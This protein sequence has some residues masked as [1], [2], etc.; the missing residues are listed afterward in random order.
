ML[1][2]HKPTDVC[3][4]AVTSC[5]RSKEGLSLTR[6]VCTT[7]GTPHAHRRVGGSDDPW[8][9]A[10]AAAFRREYGVCFRSALRVVRERWLAEEVV[11][12]AFLAAWQHGPTR[13]DPR[14][15]PLELWLI[16][17][18][19]HKAIDAVR[20]AEH[21]KRVRRHEEGDLHSAT[22]KELT[23]DLLLRSQAADGLRDRIRSL[24]VAQQRVLLL[25]YWAGLSQSQIAQCDAIPLGTVKTR[26]SAGL[27]HLRILL[28]DP[29]DA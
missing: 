26:T 1:D 18:T 28:L 13:F 10:L 29:I 24:P 4:T 12:E 14:R 5:R 22:S 9:A 25:A 15:G 2:S 8:S 20:H 6:E 23:E 19:R 3:L 16:T 11:Q 21:V 27:A 17:L 7:A